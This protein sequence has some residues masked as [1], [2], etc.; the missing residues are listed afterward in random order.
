M[1]KQSKPTKAETQAENARE[2]GFV[3]EAAAQNGQWQGEFAAPASLDKLEA[4][5]D[6]VSGYMA[7]LD[8]SPQACMH[9]EIAVEEIFVNIASYAYAPGEAGM[10]A[11]R[12][13]A[14]AGA[15]RLTVVFAD[16][17]APYNPLD[18]PDPDVGLPL[19]E[20]PIGGLGVFMI[21]RLMD[22]VYYRFEAGRN[23]LT[24]V[25]NRDRL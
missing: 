14:D 24:I 11:I 8:F 17:G 9:V 18:R 21:K 23:M 10:A 3:P 16:S 25:K 5:Q 6:F 13:E 4:V 1:K 7:Y 12:C 15:G 20:R 22:A 2:S 19:E